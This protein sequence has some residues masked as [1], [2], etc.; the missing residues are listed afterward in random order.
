M[1]HR[2]Q[3]YWLFC[4]IHYERIEP[5]GMDDWKSLFVEVTGLGSPGK[6]QGT[7]K[8]SLMQLDYALNFKLTNRREPQV[9]TSMAL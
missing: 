4:L 2:R 6:I 8:W 3:I 5:E 9:S 1:A 7:L